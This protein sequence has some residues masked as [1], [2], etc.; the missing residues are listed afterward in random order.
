META[1]LKKFRKG[2]TRGGRWR[3][4]GSKGE[5]VVAAAVFCFEDGTCKRLF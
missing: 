1:Y 2:R 5:F 3:E 4:G